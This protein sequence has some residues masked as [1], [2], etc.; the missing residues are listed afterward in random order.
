MHP[1]NAST[2]PLHTLLH[3]P[4]LS[5]CATFTEGT[6]LE[7]LVSWHGLA[8]EGK[9]TQPWLPWHPL[10]PWQPMEQG[11]MGKALRSSTRHGR[12]C[13]PSGR[14][15]M[16]GGRWWRQRAPE[17]GGTVPGWVPKRRRRGPANGSKEGGEKE[18]R[19]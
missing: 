9:G 6:L 10:A 2:L 19:G 11:G 12:R 5:S 17:D 3:T 1:A 15:R 7:H 8:G 14:Q 13:Q 18:E 4:A 16:A